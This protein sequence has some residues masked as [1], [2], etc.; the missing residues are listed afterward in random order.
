MIAPAGKWW[1]RCR[2][3]DLFDTRAE[4]EAAY[5]VATGLDVTPSPDTKEG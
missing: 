4:A 2:G 1:A 5:R 3:S